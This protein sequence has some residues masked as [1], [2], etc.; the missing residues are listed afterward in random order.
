MLLRVPGF[1]V[2]TVQA[3]ISARRHRRLRLEDLKRLNVSLK[4]VRP[5]IVAEGWTPMKLTERSDLRSLFA[6]PPEQLALL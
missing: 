3:V 4:K 1:G 2:K 5:F 6:P